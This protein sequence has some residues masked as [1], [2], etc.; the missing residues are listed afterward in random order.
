MKFMGLLFFN[1]I[2]VVWLKLSEPQQTQN[3]QGK[4]TY[5][6]FLF[7]VSITS[8]VMHKNEKRSLRC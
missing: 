7:H 2:L 1:E 4:V 8:S 3:L 5:Y 6:I